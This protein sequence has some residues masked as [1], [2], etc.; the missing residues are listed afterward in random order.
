MSYT[1]PEGWQKDQDFNAKYPNGTIEKGYG[2]EGK[3]VL[4]SLACGD[5]WWSIAQDFTEESASMCECSSSSI[6][7][8]LVCV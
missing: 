8:C 3:D 6:Y 5:M 4:R 1:L 2:P 7:V